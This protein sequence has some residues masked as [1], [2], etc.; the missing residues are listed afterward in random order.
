MKV[1]AITARK[2]NKPITQAH[3][4]DYLNAISDKG[5]VGN[6]RYEE[7][8][9]LHCH[10][11]IKSDNIINYNTMR[12]TK[13]GWNVKVVPVYNMEGWISYIN[14]HSCEDKEDVRFL[15]DEMDMSKLT[16]SLFT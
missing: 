16:K 7:K 10:Y 4:E 5:S 6:V 12:P 13:R 15:P 8:R 3:Y 1:Y 11:T 2:T 9:G 14:K